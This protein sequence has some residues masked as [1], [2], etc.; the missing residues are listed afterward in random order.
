MKLPLKRSGWVPRLTRRQRVVRNLAAAVVALFFAWAVC[1]F[2]APTLALAARWQAARYGL[3]APAGLYCAD[4]RGGDAILQWEDGRLAI[5][6][7]YSG[8][9]NWALG[10]FWFTEPENGGA[11]LVPF[12]TDID[13][14]HTLYFRTEQT[15]A[16]RAEAS[17]RIRT[18]VNVSITD[19]DGSSEEAHYDWDVT[20]EMEAVPDRNGLCHFE[21]PLQ[22]GE[23]DFRLQA[24]A[25]RSALWEFANAYRKVSGVNRAAEF[26]VSFYDETGALLDTWEKELYNDLREEETP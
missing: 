8:P 2:P 26:S 1:D 5:T 6:K 13:F 25:E 12:L 24:S 15:G 23:N 19:S 4:A 11:L 16:V 20:Y 10:D 14:D 17:L 22:Y 21:I 18:E 9:L 3:P 7:C